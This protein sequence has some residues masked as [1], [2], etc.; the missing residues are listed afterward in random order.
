[1]RKKFKSDKG[2]IIRIYLKIPETQQQKDNSIKKW[3]KLK[4]FPRGNTYAS[5]QSTPK[6]ISTSLIT[7]EMKSKLQ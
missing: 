4:H 7:K 1:M 3:A 2:L 6:M 5:G